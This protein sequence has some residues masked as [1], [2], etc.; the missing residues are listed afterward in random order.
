MAELYDRQGD[1]PSARAAREEFV[2]LWRDADPEL[3]PLVEE[4]RAKLAATSR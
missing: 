4:V 2:Q 1:T 3:Q